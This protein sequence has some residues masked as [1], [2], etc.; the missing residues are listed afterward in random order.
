MRPGISWSPKALLYTSTGFWLPEVLLSQ[1]GAGGKR[2]NPVLE[3]KGCESG[4]DRD[5]LNVREGVG[6]ILD[7]GEPEKMIVYLNFCPICQGDVRGA[8]GKECNI[9]LAHFLDV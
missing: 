1:V 7:G 8:R 6:E 5:N 3:M 4:R 2:E 9:H